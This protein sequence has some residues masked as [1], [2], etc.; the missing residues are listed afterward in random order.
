[1]IRILPAAFAHLLFAAS[2]GAE[3]DQKRTGCKRLRAARNRQAGDHNENQ[4]MP[5][6]V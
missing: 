5:G 4:A 1:M 2:A 6:R 3:T